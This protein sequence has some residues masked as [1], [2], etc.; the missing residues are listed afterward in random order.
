MTIFFANQMFV[1]IASAL[2]TVNLTWHPL[3]A[4][5]LMT[6]MEISRDNGVRLYSEKANFSSNTFRGIGKYLV[7]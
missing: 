7:S 1:L 3:T 4:Y 2:A 5:E 6:I